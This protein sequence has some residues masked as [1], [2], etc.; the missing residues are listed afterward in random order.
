[1]A[2][3]LGPFSRPTLPTTV[4]HS[5]RPRSGR[6]LQRPDEESPS[7][8]GYPAPKGCSPSPGAG[9]FGASGGA[10]GG[11]SSTALAS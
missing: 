5:F 4:P 9:S 10:S 2:R 8:T 6:R 7:A 11:L 3:Q 1:M